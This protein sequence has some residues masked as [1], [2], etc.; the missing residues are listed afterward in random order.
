MLDVALVEPAE[1]AASSWHAGLIS[2]ALLALLLAGAAYWL[3]PNPWKPTSAATMPSTVVR[4]EPPTASVSATEETPPP[5][6]LSTAEPT[7]APRAAILSAPAPQP[8]PLLRTPPKK[9]AAQPG[10]LRLGQKRQLS[11]PDQEY[12]LEDLHGKRVHLTGV[13]GT[14]RIGAL[15]DGSWLDGSELA[16]REI[17]FSGTIDGASTVKLRL[18]GATVE[19][20]APIKGRSSIE[21]Q[22]PGGKVT[23]LN[24]T[25]SA[26]A[27]EGESRIRVLAKEVDFRGVIGGLTTTVDI[28]LSADGVLRFQGLDGRARLGYQRADSADPEPRVVP[29]WVRAGAQFRRLD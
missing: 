17:L 12:E 8:P 2:A 10:V 14:L 24:L 3:F 1:I 6:P 29:G 20:R 22:A 11:L 4:V 13:V 16:A 5:L 21:V 23:F 9:E 27:I 7:P 28:I 19:F 18:A 25:S 15:D 26:P